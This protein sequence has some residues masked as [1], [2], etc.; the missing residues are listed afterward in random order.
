MDKSVNTKRGNYNKVM[1]YVICSSIIKSFEKKYTKILD[2]FFVFKEYDDLKFKEDLNLLLASF[3]PAFCLGKSLNKDNDILT[4]EFK[5]FLDK[6]YFD[7]FLNKHSINVSVDIKAVS[8]DSREIEIDLIHLLSHLNTLKEQT[9]EL[10]INNK[11]GLF[12]E[13]NKVSGLNLESDIEKLKINSD[14]S[15]DLFDDLDCDDE[16]EDLS[17][18]N[19]SEFRLND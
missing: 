3:K 5:Y 14:I 10:C 7:G 17:K 6:D 18:Y 16:C 4:D 8:I 19:M 15:N 1:I 11:E 12:N 9:I 13:L 2:G